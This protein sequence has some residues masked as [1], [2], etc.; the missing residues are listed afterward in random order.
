MISILKWKNWRRNYIR[1]TVYFY[2]KNTV[3]SARGQNAGLSC[4]FK[5]RGEGVAEI[6]VE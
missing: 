6:S 3:F 5:K 4:K 2:S 1:K